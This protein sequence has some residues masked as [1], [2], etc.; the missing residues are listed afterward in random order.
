MGTEEVTQS[1]I[2]DWLTVQVAN[3]LKCPPEDVGFEE[4]FT[5]LGLDSLSLIM[6]TGNFAAWLGRDLPATLLL[7]HP[8][9]EEVS[10]VLTRPMSCELEL[11]PL[12]SDRDQPFPATLAQ[13]RL[14]KHANLPPLRDPNLVNPR[15]EIHGSLDME[16]LRKALA[17]LVCRHEILRTTF[18]LQEGAF[19]QFVHSEGPVL[20]EEVDWTLDAPAL[21]EEEILVRARRLVVEPMDIGILPLFRV[22]VIKVAEENHR[23]MFVLHHLLCDA[24]ALCVF[25]EELGRVYA[26][27]R[28]GFPPA[29]EPLNWQI[30]DFAIWERDWLRV[31]GEPYQERL[32]WWRRYWQSPPETPPLPFVLK[33]PLSDVPARA[34]TL[35]VPIA[36]EIGRQAD[37]LARQTSAT[38]FTVFLA[39]FASY[40]CSRVRQE[41]LILG[42]YVSDRKRAAAGRLLGMFVS[43]V[44]MRVRIAPGITFRALVIQLRKERDQIA[45]YRELP[46]EDVLHH[47]QENGE[48]MPEV[49]VVF[50]HLRLPGDFVHLEGTESKSWLEHGQRLETTGLSFSTV[51]GEQD[52]EAWASFDGKLYDPEEVGAFLK[53]YVEHVGTLVNDPEQHLMLQDDRSDGHGWKT[54]FGPG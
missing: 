30:A 21:S 8:S 44:P 41:E 18:G 19:V 32:A 11:Q 15:F 3:I 52:L 33:E 51:K 37:L 43:M 16:A 29:L 17:E 53:G 9:I 34:C 25:F 28:N 20:V 7:E 10:E 31:G 54:L 36:S 24:D 26:A 50:Q 47:L 48:A 4:S 45:L 46:F 49:Q 22:L 12:L 6:L 27:F 14:L 40:L 13:E 39:A 35:D 2:R 42:T 1:D 38:L 23:L 5:R